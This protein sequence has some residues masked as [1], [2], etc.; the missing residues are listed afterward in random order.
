M[1]PPS[2]TQKTS[3]FLNIYILVANVFKNFAIHS[4]DILYDM[5]ELKCVFNFAI[6]IPISENSTKKHVYTVTLLIEITIKF[7]ILNL[8]LK[9][10]L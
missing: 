10:K 3:H 8:R 4:V 6:S 9:Q 7:L 1:F 2:N 5:E